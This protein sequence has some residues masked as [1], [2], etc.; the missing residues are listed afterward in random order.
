MGK[1]DLGEHA[2]LPLARGERGVA[3]EVLRQ[4]HLGADV[5]HQRHALA[6]RLVGSRLLFRKIVE[7]TS[8]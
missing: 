1:R 8:A 4:H 6:P 2:V 5:V 3:I 7:H